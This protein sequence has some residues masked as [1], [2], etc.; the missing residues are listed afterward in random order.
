M[1]RSEESTLMSCCCPHSQSASKFFSLFAKSYRR[2]FDKKGFEPSQQQLVAG[3]TKANFKDKSLLEIGCGVGHLHQT[4][5]EQGA[6]STIGIE[7][8]DKM[9]I[10]AKDWA[11]QRELSDKIN[12][13]EGDFIDLANSIEAVDFVIMDKVV[14]CYPDADALIHRSLEKCQHSIALTYP[15][16]TWY[17]RFGVHVLAIIMKILG[18]DFRPYVHNPT[19]IEAWITEQGFKKIFQQ[20]TTIWLSQV[21]QK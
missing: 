20:Q 19:Q 12:Y 18:S 5:L 17:T 3:I 21:Y 1:Y 2:R 13:I 14:C 9:L 6:K 8:S 15:R 11:K 7:L 4:L 10:E 16:K